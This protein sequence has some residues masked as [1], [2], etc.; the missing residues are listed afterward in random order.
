LVAGAVAVGP[1]LAVGATR[2]RA[3]PALRAAALGLIVAPVA[4]GLLLRLP[5]EVLL[6]HRRLVLGVRRAD[7]PGDVLDALGRVVRGVLDR[8]NRDLAYGRQLRGSAAR[9]A[10]DRAL[11]EGSRRRRAQVGQR[12]ARRRAQVDRRLGALDEGEACG[13]TPAGQLGRRRETG[14]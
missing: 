12:G 9:R 14:R 10:T 13:A 6:A 2:L 11:A 3:E 8:Q 7:D 5:R 1:R 4:L